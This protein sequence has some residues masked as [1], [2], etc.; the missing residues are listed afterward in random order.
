MT[1]KKMNVLDRLLCVFRPKKEICP[2]IIAQADNVIEHYIYVK[3]RLIHRKCKNSKNSDLFLNIAVFG[4]AVILGIT[5][6]KILI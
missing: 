4:T 6:F 3:N 2:D 1:D 5:V